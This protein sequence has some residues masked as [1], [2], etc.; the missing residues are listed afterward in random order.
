MKYPIIAVVLSILFFTHFKILAQDPTFT[1]WE[2]MPLHF[3]PALTG[4]FE[5]EFRFGLKYRDQ[6]RSILQEDAFKTGVASAEYKL[7]KGDKRKISLGFY[8]LLDKA[9]ESDFTTNSYQISSSIIQNIGNPED[10]H[11]SI[12]VGVQLGM[13]AQKVDVTQLGFGPDGM[14]FEDNFEPKKKYPDLSIGLLWNYHSKTHFSSQF[15][16]ALNH[17]NRPNTSFSGNSVSRLSARFNLHGH[18]EIPVANQISMV[19][20]FLFLRQGPS[21]Q[22]LFGLSNKWYLN[23]TNGNFVQFGFFGKLTK[24]FNGRSINAYAGSAIIEINSI[25][26]GFSYDRFPNVLTGSS[27]YE[28]S[29]G[30]TIGRNNSVKENL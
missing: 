1:Q 30:Y 13:V 2:H 18:I 29:L 16:A 15:G 25:L 21:E 12:A 5:G 7:A 28:F 10:A 19:P 9:G 20:S 24:N 14:L 3:N 8:T 4:D 23:Q 17:I 26:V 11:H 22:L 6:W 27:A